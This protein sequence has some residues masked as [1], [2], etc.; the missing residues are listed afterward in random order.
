MAL[1]YLTKHNKPNCVTNTPRTPRTFSLHQYWLASIL[2]DL[3]LEKW[4]RALSP[5]HFIITNIINYMQQ[6]N[7]NI[8][9]QQKGCFFWGGG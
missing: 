7:T 6:E 5:K 4:G 8:F 9:K 1:A 2:K 3:F